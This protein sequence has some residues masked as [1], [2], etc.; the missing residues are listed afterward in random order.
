MQ[1][2][3]LMV[4][5]RLLQQ[6]TDFL[7]RSQEYD[8]LKARIRDTEECLALCYRK[9][10]IQSS[11]YTASL[12]TDRKRFMKLRRQLGLHKRHK[13]HSYQSKAY[14]AYLEGEDPF[15]KPPYKPRW[16]P[17]HSNRVNKGL[18]RVAL[19]GMKQTGVLKYMSEDGLKAVSGTAFYY[20]SKPLT[21]E[22]LDEAIGIIK[23]HG[24]P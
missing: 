19:A 7:K 14:Q 3:T 23:K 5:H 8:E 10:F 2:D 20:K 15:G 1:P 4:P 24:E 6:A 12:R 13:P 11:W 9:G 18:W 17:P 16:R 22:S 21:S